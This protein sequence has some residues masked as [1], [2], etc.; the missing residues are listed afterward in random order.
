MLDQE[1]V[2]TVSPEAALAG[3]RLGM[4]RGG[5]STIAPA[6]VLLDRDHKKEE[7]AFDAIAMALLQFT[8][9][10]TFADDFSI[11]LDVTA[12]LT[13]FGGRL[14]LCRRLRASIVA[15]GFTATM[16]TAPTA[17]GAWLLARCSF[18]RKRPI[19]RRTIKLESMFRQL[20]RL[21]C[22]LL[23]S[24]ELHREWLQ[25]I[26]CDTL[27]QLRKLPRAGLQ[28]RTNTHLLDALDKAYGTAP[29]LFVWIKIP[30]VF[31]AR[32]ETHDRIEHAEALLFGAHRLILQLIGWL[33]S[34]QQAVTRFVISLEHE[35]GRAAIAPT[36]I[37]IVLSE[38]T[39]REEHL[40]RLL[41]E[42]LGRVEL[43]AP[44]IA[45]RLDV[46]HFEVMLPPTESLFPEPGG[47]PADYRR[48][49]ELLTARLGK[50]NVLTLVNEADHRPEQANCWM[51]AT[52][53]RPKYEELTETLERP[54]WLLD[55]PIP[56]LMR[57]DRPFY[58]SP[59]KLIKGPE[60]IESGWFDD[61]MAARDYFIGQTKDATCYWLYLERAQEAQW[62]LHGLFA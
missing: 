11:L 38:P 16:S 61:K 18:P 7:L 34:L 45:L 15:L 58:G 57:D 22:H 50:D 26:G 48:L 42:R 13:Y 14:A 36:P 25:G 6:T 29:E 33:V 20:D 3:V 27:D 32:I 4:R 35:R 49:L 47:S 31:G 17:M 43:D 41:K 60:R 8:P 5:V 21:P 44:V 46:T 10:V 59:L 28:R 55:K 52:D 23:P 2:R 24:A 54:F 62:F 30:Q 39:W 1:R 9:E 19:R 12:S 37:E 40:M 56:L 53:K 51:P